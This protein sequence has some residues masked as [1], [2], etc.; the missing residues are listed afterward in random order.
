M[1]LIVFLAFISM[2]SISDKY[3]KQEVVDNVI[4]YFL[5][6]YQYYD[7]YL[8]DKKYVCSNLEP[9]AKDGELIKVYPLFSED[10]ASYVIKSDG[11]YKF[12]ISECK[13]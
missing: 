13:N 10:K 3:K 11:D 7:N 2:R 6:E 8:G 5:Y 4:K 9:L 12:G 1:L